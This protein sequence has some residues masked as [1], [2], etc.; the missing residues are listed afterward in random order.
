MQLLPIDIVHLSLMARAFVS[1]Y[2]SFMEAY[3]CLET[4]QKLNVPETESI[5][6]DYLTLNYNDQYK[7]WKSKI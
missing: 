2:P 3:T 7:K 1:T 4:L 5:I 6:D